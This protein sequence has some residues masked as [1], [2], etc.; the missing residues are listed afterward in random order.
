LKIPF[1]WAAHRRRV[2]IADETGSIVTPSGTITA[3]EKKNV[4]SITGYAYIFT[5]ALVKQCL[6]DTFMKKWESD[7]NNSSMVKYT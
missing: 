3:L 6:S 1:I 4:G 2:Y 5:I 7:I